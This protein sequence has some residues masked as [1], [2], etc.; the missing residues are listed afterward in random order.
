VGSFLH[1][2]QEIRGNSK[3]ISFH[4]EMTLKPLL[5]AY[6]QN[7]MDTIFWVVPQKINTASNATIYKVDYDIWHKR[8]GHPSKDVLKCARELKDFPNDLVFPEHSPL[9]RGCAEG[10]LHSKSFPESD[11]RASTPFAL[12][13]SDLKEF[14]IE[15]YSKFK[16][17]VS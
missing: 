4:D 14:P 7:P 8:L 9:C 17:L 16:Y 15:S 13:H 12:V 6:P 1:N 3:C 2:Q 11:S 5:S 10:K